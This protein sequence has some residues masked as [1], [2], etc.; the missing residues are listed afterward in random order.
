VIPEV[1]SKLSYQFIVAFFV[2]SALLTSAVAYYAGRVPHSGAAGAA[3]LDPTTLV[4]AV[5]IVSAGFAVVLQAVNFF[6]IRVL[7]GASG[8]PKWIATRLRKRWQRRMKE[9]IAQI[10][11][12]KHTGGQALDEAYRL[13]KERYTV[14][15][16]REDDVLPTRLGNVIAA[17]EHYPYRRYGI[18][19][20]VLWPRLAPLLSKPVAEA[21]VEAKARF[22]LFCNALV[23]LPLW[24]LVRATFFAQPNET[25]RRIAWVAITAAA[26]LGLWQMCLAAAA[27]W[28]ETVKA[29]FDLH[30][31]DVLKQMGVAD[32][33]TSVTTAQEKAL[34]QQVEWP[35][36]FDF[37]SDI[38]ITPRRAST[39][40]NATQSEKAEAD[41]N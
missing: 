19:A 16:S 33:L 38:L 27:A 10:T 12:L 7:E 9:M 11:H 24:G 36:K 40:A 21:I 3:A 29:A 13:E 20:I 26:A 25:W 15:P 4:G 2:P 32:S 18:D 5:F 31:L 17:W 35:M 41:T 39:V 28:G 37:T 6:L 8:I 1:A 34:W 23:L 30:R 14:Y 22:D